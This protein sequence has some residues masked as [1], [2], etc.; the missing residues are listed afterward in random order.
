MKKLNEYMY[1][2]TSKIKIEFKKAS[3]R[4]KR[5]VPSI[6]DKTLTIKESVLKKIKNPT[7]AEKISYIF[8]GGFIAFLVLLF[9]AGK[10]VKI[11]TTES[12]PRGIY[13]VDNNVDKIQRGDMIVF[14]YQSCCRIADPTTPDAKY[15]LK[16]VLGLPGDK[17]KHLDKDTIKIISKKGNSIKKLHLVE[18]SR[19]GYKLP[20]VKEGVIPPDY[21]FVYTEEKKSFDSRYY[22]LINK[23][24]IKAKA[25][26]LWIYQSVRKTQP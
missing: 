15:F 2:I 19:G 11:N 3:R 17:I 1:L 21:Y 20:K 24:Y 6:K 26:P 22:G 4:L 23:E 10:F 9:F 5:K 16:I 14:D 12:M 13:L 18:R 7:R 8:A 25:T